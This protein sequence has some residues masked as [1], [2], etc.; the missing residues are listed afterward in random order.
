MRMARPECDRSENIVRA[1][2]TA[3]W[4]EVNNRAQSGLFIGPNTSVSRL[5]VSG[6]P[7]LM[8]IFL[9]DLE[10]P[11][12]TLLWAGEIN[13]GKLQ[14]LGINYEHKRTTITVEV[15]PTETN[16]AHAEIPQKLSRGLAILI[17]GSLKRHPAP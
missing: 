13:V 2:T 1:V 15:E 7:E 4:D 12:I 3:L 5:A 14:D 8:Q 11:P 16:P 17:G 10:R 6:L 9:R